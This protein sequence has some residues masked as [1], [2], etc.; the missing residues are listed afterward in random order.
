MTTLSI[1][2]RTLI[3]GA[4]ALAIAL[5]PAVAVRQLQRPGTAGAGMSGDRDRGQLR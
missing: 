4:V 3:Y 5:T 2:G 1:R